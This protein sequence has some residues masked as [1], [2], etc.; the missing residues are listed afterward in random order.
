MPLDRRIRTGAIVALIGYSVF[1]AFIGFWPVPVDRPF[2]PALF[3]LLG[4][5]KGVGV[6]PI[7]AYTVI[8]FT[9]NVAFFVIPAIL[10]VLIAGRRRW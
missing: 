6:R 10:V 8:E 5:L 4:A 3:R 2:D 1:V 9:A 7:D